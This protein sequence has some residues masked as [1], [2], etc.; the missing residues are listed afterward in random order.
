MVNGMAVRSF[1]PLQN[2][3]V[4]RR[5]FTNVGGPLYQLCFKPLQNGAVYRS[6]RDQ[7]PRREGLEVSN[8]FRTGRYIVAVCMPKACSLTVGSFKPLQNGAV[9][10]RVR[11]SAVVAFE[12]KFQTPSERGGIS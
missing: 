10:R 6:R 5:I 1:K 4:Y 2:G 11:L 7:D 8:P 12:A 9:Y 3:A